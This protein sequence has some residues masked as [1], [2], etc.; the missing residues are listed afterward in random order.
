MIEIDIKTLPLKAAI[1]FNKRGYID[2]QTAIIHI[3]S[4]YKITDEANTISDT[5]L[6]IAF[7]DVVDKNHINAMNM[8]HAEI[9]KHFVFALPREITT[10]IICCAGGFSRSPA[11]AAGILKGL[12]YSDTHIWKNPRYSP[13]MLCYRMMLKAY[14]KSTV[15]ACLKK[16]INKKA[17]SKAQRKKKV[18]VPRSWMNHTTSPA[19][20]TQN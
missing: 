16:C 5:E 12:G 9:I 7:D 11:I 6:W 13:N 19:T 2:N 1:L 10:L 14:G 15:F 18:E 4:V 8:E 3:L 20:K 17:F